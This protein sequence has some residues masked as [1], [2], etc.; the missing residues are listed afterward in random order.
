MRRTWIIIVLVLLAIATA[1]GVA[2]RERLAQA[3]VEI[4]E[5]KGTYQCAMH[6]QIVSDHPDVCPICQMKLQRV[7]EPARAAS[8]TS[9][10]ILF[11]RHPMRP[12]VTS[13]TPAKDEM[14][15]DYIP[16]YDDDGSGASGTI[17]GRAGFT[18]SPERQQ[19]IGVTTT[20]LELRELSREIRAAG[21]IAYDPRLYQAIVEYREAIAAK[22]GVK[23]SQW[24]EAQEGADAIVRAAILKLRQLGIPDQQLRAIAES[25]R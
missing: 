15:M 7:D 10:R 5:A 12:D 21:R 3:P 1:V 2:V 9:R 16:V 23:D 22:Q 11:Y 13:T 18:L 19:L 25:Q 6:P 17:A 4:V 8:A 14:G 20:T 24:R